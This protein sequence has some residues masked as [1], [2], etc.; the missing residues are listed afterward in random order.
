MSMIH[1]NC[2]LVGLSA[3]LSRGTARL[4][5]VRSMTV[6]MHGSART[7]S[8]IHSLRVAFGWMLIH[9]CVEPERPGSTSDVS[10]WAFAGLEVLVWAEAAHARPQPYGGYDGAR[11]GQRDHLHDGCLEHQ[12]RSGR[13]A[14]GWRRPAHA[15]RLARDGGHRSAPGEAR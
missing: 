11:N 7:R 2:A 9:Q 5:T 4:S 15:R 1:S 6:T 14:R 8:A 13:Y 3:S 12:V 10:A